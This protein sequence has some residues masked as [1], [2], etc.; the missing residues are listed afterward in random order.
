MFK[1][2]IK[3]TLKALLVAFIL[4]QFYRPE[5]NIASRPTDLGIEKA[6]PVPPEVATMLRT[7]CYD[8]HSN[9]TNYPWYSNVQPVGWWLADH[10]KD[11]K[12]EVNFDE[13]ASYRLRRQYRKF[14]EIDEQVSKDEMPLPSYTIIHQ[15]AI[16]S[17]DQKTMLVTWSRA[18]MDS[19][20][21]KY[22]IDSL[23]R[24]PKS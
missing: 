13:F 16:L 9:T 10:I 24:K 2:I 1:K 21:A 19:M 20:K 4:I 12:D 8:C 3:I 22:P 17:P 14:E 7:S 5:R 11:A 23:V 15:N 6:F 18:M